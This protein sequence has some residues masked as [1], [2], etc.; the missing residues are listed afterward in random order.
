MKY[1]IWKINDSRRAYTDLIEK[2][3]QLP[4]I[5]VDCI[6]GYDE[7]ELDRQLGITGMGGEFDYLNTP[8]EVGVWLTFIN[9]LTYIANQNEPVVTFEDD[10]ILIDDFMDMFE[11]R[12][13]G[14]PHD[15]DF[16]SLFIPRDHS[17]WCDYIPE[18]DSRG[19]ILKGDAIF[20]GRNRCRVNHKIF[21]AW[22]R[23]GGVSMLWSPAGARK[24]LDHIN[25][26][27][28]KQWDEYVYALSR[29]NILKGFT[30]NP[31]LPDL[32]RISGTEDSLVH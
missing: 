5:Y 11:D 31:D 12:I 32:V 24:T 14:L 1:T 2:Q 17:H 9:T 30:S 20:I 18:M 27:V 29:R 15:F 6:N 13:G 21:K 4:R 8:G 23:Y 26:E 3:V 16:F 19:V 25:S 22:Q 28:F 10:A 7:S